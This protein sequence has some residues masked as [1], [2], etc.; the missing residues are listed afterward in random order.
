MS[1]C[2][3]VS[4]D[5]SKSLRC[6][7]PVTTATQ[8]SLSLFFLCLCL[9]SPFISPPH[10]SQVM[11]LHWRQAGGRQRNELVC[12]LLTN[13]LL[14]LGDSESLSLTVSSVSVTQSLSLS[15]LPP[16]YPPLLFFPPL[17]CSYV[18]FFLLLFSIP[19]CCFL[20]CCCFHKLSLREKVLCDGLLNSLYI[21]TKW[22]KLP[23]FSLCVCIV[24]FSS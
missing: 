5:L 7:V 18:C 9:P 22:G 2:A 4:D 15:S 11:W 24:C 14:R 17:S 13:L 20:C 23:V 1:A 10:Q 3:C 12:G 19:A 6:S 16:P 21:A 8:A